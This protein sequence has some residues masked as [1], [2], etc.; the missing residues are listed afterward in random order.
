MYTSQKTSI[1]ISAG[2]QVS[3]WFDQ[4]AETAQQLV[5][6]SSLRRAA[7]IAPKGSGRI[8][9]ATCRACCCGACLFR[10]M[11]GEQLL[12]WCAPLLFK[13]RDPRPN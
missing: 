2:V 4:Q 8:F 11:S 9:L 13:Q 3:G 10:F 7:N 6:T 12:G 5:R 1:S